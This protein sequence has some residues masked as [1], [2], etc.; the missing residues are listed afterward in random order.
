MAAAGQVAHAFD[1]EDY[2]TTYRAT[3]DAYYKAH[4]ELRLAYGKHRLYAGVVALYGWAEHYSGGS[5]PGELAH[6]GWPELPESRRCRTRAS[7][8]GGA[9]PSFP[10]ANSPENVFVVGFRGYR[11][12]GAGQYQAAGGDAYL[13]FRT[14]GYADAVK[15][16]GDYIAIFPFPNEADRALAQSVLAADLALLDQGITPS[17]Q[18]PSK[19]PDGA[20]QSTESLK[21]HYELEFGPDNGHNYY[22]GDGYNWINLPPAPVLYGEY[23]FDDPN[24]C[25]ADVACVD[26]SLTYG[27]NV[28]HW[29]VD[30]NTGYAQADSPYRF[31]CAYEDQPAVFPPKRVDPLARENWPGLLGVGDPADA[32]GVHARNGV[33]EGGVIA[34]FHTTYRATRDAYKKAQQER[35]LAYGPFEAARAADRVASTVYFESILTMFE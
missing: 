25:P 6:Y 19:D 1:L 34:D 10:E 13:H 24:L 18:H 31:R 26:S 21:W 16:V 4:E 22:N 11:P 8:Y 5:Y 33:S 3:R 28:P 9:S 2:A 35:N 20:N 30:P 12:A 29:L 23:C 27:N 7:A 15:A 17:E 14:A 32:P